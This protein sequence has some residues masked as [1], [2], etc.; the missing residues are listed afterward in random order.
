LQFDVVRYRLESE[1]NAET[2]VEWLP[3]K[4]ARWVEG[5]PEQVAQ[6]HVPYTSRLV[7]DQFGNAVVL[8]QTPWD[9][10]YMRRENPE[11]QFLAIR[12]ATRRDNLP[13]AVPADSSG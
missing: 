4:L 10:E 3:Y 1:Y 6:L 11:M 2:D 13:Q 12:T 7:Q 8:Y 9:A 5:T